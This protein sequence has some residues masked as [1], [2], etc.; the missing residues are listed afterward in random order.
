MCV[1]LGIYLFWNVFV[2]DDGVEDGSV[3]GGMMGKLFGDKR[4]VYSV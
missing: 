2:C 4:C 1:I 3:S